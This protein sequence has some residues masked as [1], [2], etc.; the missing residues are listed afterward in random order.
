ML[1]PSVWKGRNQTLQYGKQQASMIVD[2]KNINK[3]RDMLSVRG[4]HRSRKIEILV[5]MW[6]HAFFR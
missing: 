1:S 6:K 2:M 4:A 3:D 5:I